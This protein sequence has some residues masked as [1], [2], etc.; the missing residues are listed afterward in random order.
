MMNLCLGVQ[1][2]SRRI[3]WPD[4]GRKRVD[5]MDKNVKHTDLSYLT[6]EQV[7]SLIERYYKGESIKALLNDYDLQITPNLLVTIFPKKKTDRVC[8]MCGSPVWSKYVSRSK[9]IKDH[10]SYFCPTCG[11]LP[12]A[13][14]CICPVC[15]EKRNGKLR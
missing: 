12:G 14:Y 9:P 1:L 10:L 13:S 4:A 8:E 5:S 7:A 3:F 6:K 15:K 11:H 2:M